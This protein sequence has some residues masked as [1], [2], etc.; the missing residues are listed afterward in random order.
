[1]ARET[2]ISYLGNEEKPKIRHIP[3]A[4]NLRVFPFLGRLQMDVKRRVD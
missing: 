3:E 2:L 4:L 1:M